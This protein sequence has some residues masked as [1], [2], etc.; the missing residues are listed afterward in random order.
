MLQNARV[1]AFAVSLLLKENQQEGVKLPP[2][3][4][5]HPH[6]QPRLGLMY[7]ICIYNNFSTFEKYFV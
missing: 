3:N 6:H 1:T 2:R 7:K 4:P 5:H